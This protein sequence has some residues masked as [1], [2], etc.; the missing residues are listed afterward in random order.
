MTFSQLSQNVQLSSKCMEV[1]GLS[2]GVAPALG[3]AHA[4]EYSFIDSRSATLWS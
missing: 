4:A 1:A 2:N 3:V